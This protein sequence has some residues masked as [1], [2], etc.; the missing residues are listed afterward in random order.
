MV[1]LGKSIDRVP[2]SKAA[3]YQHAR[4]A[5]YQV[6]IWAN[7]LSRCPEPMDPTKW[8]WKRVES[9]LEHYWS[10]LPEASKACRE[11][12]K[13]KCK[14]GCKSRCKCR[15]TKLPCTELCLC[16]G[17]CFGL[18]DEVMDVDTNI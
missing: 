15:Q 13:C 5:I 14:K 17:N 10:E 8:G 12:V 4:R 11:F 3:L 9:S 1:S 16:S 6:M 7:S 2:P 18:T